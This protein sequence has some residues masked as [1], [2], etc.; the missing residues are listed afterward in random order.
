[1]KNEMWLIWKQ[2]KNRRRYKIGTLFYFD[3]GEYVFNYVNPELDDAI[4]DGFTY[5][6]GFDDINVEYKSKKLFA[7]IETRLPNPNRPDYLDILNRYGLDGNSNKFQILSATKGRLITD[8]YEFVSAFDSNK[9][10][11]DV[12]GTS[13]YINIEQCRKLVNVND[14]LELEFDSENHHDPYAIKVVF[15]KDGKCYHLGYVPRY[16]SKQLLQLLGKNVQYSALVQSLNLESEIS[17]E[18]ITVSVKLIF[19]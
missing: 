17:D 14:K 2:P 10:E 19:N 12:A 6:P 1:M 13:H 5:F 11:F 8:N 9:I 7:N 4:S 3:N 16:Y 18:S 15:N